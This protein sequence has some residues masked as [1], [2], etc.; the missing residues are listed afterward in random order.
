MSENGR[1]VG[2]HVAQFSIFR[3]RGR[4]AVAANDVLRDM[5]VAAKPIIVRKNGQ[6]IGFRLDGVCSPDQ[7]PKIVGEEIIYN[8]KGD[9]RIQI[10][11]PKAKPAPDQYW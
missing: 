8:A 2:P 4:H 6:V 11:I 10:D 5:G 1:F 9:T 7:F 3:L